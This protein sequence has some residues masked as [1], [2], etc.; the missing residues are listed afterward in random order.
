MFFVQNVSKMGPDPGGITHVRGSFSPW[1]AFG[2]SGAPQGAPEAL[3][4]RISHGFGCSLL[5]R[6][7]EMTLEMS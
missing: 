7:Q 6:S 4:G 5:S 2:A 1:D 3:P